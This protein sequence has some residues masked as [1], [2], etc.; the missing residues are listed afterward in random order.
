MSQYLYKR[1]SLKQLKKTTIKLDVGESPQRVYEVTTI[2]ILNYNIDGKGSGLVE[3]GAIEV[4]E[5]TSE[6]GRIYRSSL[7]KNS[8]YVIMSYS[9]LEEIMLSPDWIVSDYSPSDSEHPIDEI[10]EIGSHAKK[11]E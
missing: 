9:K 7:F 8:E 2:A 11:E 3:K 6:Y 1:G 10:M 4:V 5:Y